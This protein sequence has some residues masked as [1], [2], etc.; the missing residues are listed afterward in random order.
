M[1]DFSGASSFARKGACIS[2]AT[3]FGI[4]PEY[5]DLGRPFLGSGDFGS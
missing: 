2:T 4:I 5:S 3:F 1:K